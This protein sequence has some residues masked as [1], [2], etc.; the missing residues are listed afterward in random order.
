MKTKIIVLLFI[1]AVQ[2]QFVTAQ[3]ESS[4]A[5]I[6][7]GYGFGVPAYNIGASAKTTGITTDHTLEKGSYGQGLNFGIMGGYMFNQNV[8]V[9]IAVSYLVGSEKVFTYSTVA[10]DSAMGT[11]TNFDGTITFDKIKMIRIN[12]S[13]KLTMGDDVR[14]YLRMGFIIGLSTGYTRTEES[15]AVTIGS[16]TD[17]TTIEKVIDYS[18]G[19]AFGFSSAVGVDIDLTD[20]LVF[21]GELNF[22]SLAW[23]ATRSEITKY[24]YNGQDIVATAT[25][26]SLE[27][28]YV[29]DY[30]ASI[31][32]SSGSTTKVFKSYLP[33]GTFGINAG[34]AFTF[35]K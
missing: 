2:S 10:A 13:V 4:Y 1:T 14:P 20:N 25:P 9:E 29:D 26:G 19:T 21:F 5:G 17:T 3:S 8:G 16:T 31:G 23:A 24:T 12:P 18:G 30:S 27:T 32:G 35:G 11:V 28:E 33:F 7:I 34:V 22:T 6:S 15:T